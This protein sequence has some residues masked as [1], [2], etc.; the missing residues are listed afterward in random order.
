MAG[1]TVLWIIYIQHLMFSS[2]VLI[3]ARSQ[4][5]ENNFS[6]NSNNYLLYKDT[7]VE[8]S[9]ENDLTKKNAFLSLVKTQGI[10]SRLQSYTTS[11][12]LFI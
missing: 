12:T 6:E 5:V 9:N 2:P 4:N 10:I 1:I 7:A 3:T 8:A 11:T